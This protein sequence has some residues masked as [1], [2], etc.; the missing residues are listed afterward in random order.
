MFEKL[1]GSHCEEASILFNC[2]L[3]GLNQHY[4]TFRSFQVIISNGL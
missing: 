3:N 1:N 4:D 2:R